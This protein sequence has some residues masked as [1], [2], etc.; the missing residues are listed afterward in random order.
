V[1]NTTNLDVL[2]GFNMFI[3]V[4]QVF[5][6]FPLLMPLQFLFLPLGK[7]QSLAMV[8]KVTQKALEERIS[9][10]GKTK[11]IDYFDFCH[12]ADSPPP[13]DKR[14]LA[15]L[16]A[17]GTQFVFASFGPMSDWAYITLYFLFEEPEYLRILA[18]EIRSSFQRY[19]DITPDALL[20]LPYLYACLEESLRI[21]PTN[22]TGLPRYSPGAVVDGQYIP[23]GVRTP[24]VVIYKHHKASLSPFWPR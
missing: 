24:H 10:K 5:K 3:T 9:M 23:K 14:E 20:G 21:L 11:H 2:I 4:I 19:E 7:L 16:R 17:L 13:K 1:K 22:N 12:P 15:H 8:E 18:E 6:R